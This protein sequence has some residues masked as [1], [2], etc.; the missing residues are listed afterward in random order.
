MKPDKEL[1]KQSE[2]GKPG[3]SVERDLHGG[4]AS[5]AAPFGARAP[6]AL[7]LSVRERTAMLEVRDSKNG[8]IVYD[9]DADEAVMV[10]NNQREADA[11]VAELVI[12]EEH[13]K[14][15]HWSLDRV[16]PS[17]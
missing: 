1:G 8:F 12:A 17:G 3:E 7:S 13:A 6:G 9:N 15:Q 4:A 10:F 5:P 11:F 14:L 2:R 16:T